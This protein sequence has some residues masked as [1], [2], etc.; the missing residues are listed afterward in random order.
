VT[1]D[2]FAVSR[3]QDGTQ[4]RRQASQLHLAAQKQLL[5]QPSSSAKQGGQRGKGRP[6]PGGSGGAGPGPVT[7][8]AALLGTS[9]APPQAALDP[10][11]RVSEYCYGLS[12]ADV[13]AFAASAGYRGALFLC[14]PWLS[15]PYTGIAGAG[16]PPGLPAGV[17]GGGQVRRRRGSAWDAA[18][19]ANAASAAVTDGLARRPAAPPA[20]SGIGS[21]YNRVNMRNAAGSAT[22][23]GAGG[24]GG[25]RSNARGTGAAAATPPPPLVAPPAPVG[26]ER[27][28]LTSIAA[29]GRLRETVFSVTADVLGYWGYLLQQ[30]EQR[31][32]ASAPL[33]PPALDTSLPDG[34]LNSS[35]GGTAQTDDGTPAAA[36]AAT[37]TTASGTSSGSGSPSSASSASASA[38][39]LR[40]YAWECP[41]P[42]AVEPTC[43]PAAVAAQGQ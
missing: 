11:G 2:A 22:A 35:V 41:W 26:S 24:G 43:R 25:G 30:G 27:H 16:A 6:P 7:T 20:T 9:E 23:A 33:P 42:L 19:A 39:A 37:T 10:S 8:A 31:Q 3:V 13:G 21:S 4:W 12:E 5:P 1:A 28:R 18:P 36:A 15:A 34:S 32:G 29:A 17:K 14:S 38:A 40:W